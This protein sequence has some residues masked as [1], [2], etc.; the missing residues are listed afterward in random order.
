MS[1]GASRL[2]AFTKDT[3]NSDFLGTSSY[4]GYDERDLGRNPL[5]VN[6]IDERKRRS[7][8]SNREKERTNSDTLD[9]PFKVFIDLKYVIADSVIVARRLTFSGSSEGESGFWNKCISACVVC[10]V[11]APIFRAKDLGFDNFISPYATLKGKCILTGVNYASGG[12]GILDKSGQNL[13]ECFSFNKQIRNHKKTGS[14]DYINNYF[15]LG[16]V[17]YIM[18]NHIFST[19]DNSNANWNAQPED[20]DDEEDGEWTV[21]TII[22]KFF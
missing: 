4:F 13:G 18:T 22:N 2:P 9:A 14:N 21:P 12:S 10:N 1:S 15:A 19:K 3:Q 16:C 7:M 11:A 17:G 8:I 20:W 5:E 6:L